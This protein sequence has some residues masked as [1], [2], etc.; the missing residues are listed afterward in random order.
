MAR[1]AQPFAGT[2]MWQEE[3]LAW[4]EGC[5][6]VAGID[7]AGRGALAGPVVAACVVLPLEWDALGVRDSK[8]LTPAQ[9]EAALDRICDAARGIGIGMA[10]AR[11]VDVV[12]VL[13]A[14]HQAMRL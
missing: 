2:D 14:T 9:R 10:D 12:N 4:Q 11:D 8:T 5:R 3:R 13:R 7:E 6:C 1:S